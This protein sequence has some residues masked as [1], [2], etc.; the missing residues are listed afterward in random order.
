MAMQIMLNLKHPILNT[1]S[2]TY[3]IYTPPSPVG[4]WQFPGGN[5]NGSYFI[6]CYEKPSDEIILNMKTILGFNYKENINDKY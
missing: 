3:L 2:K 4:Y 6:A 1:D 5:H